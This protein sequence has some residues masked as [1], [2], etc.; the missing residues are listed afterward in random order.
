M[1]PVKEL[2]H[3]KE[4]WFCKLITS[5]RGDRVRERVKP[6]KVKFILLKEPEVYQYSGFI[7]IGYFQGSGGHVVF[8]V[9]STMEEI[10]ALFNKEEDCIK[11]YNDLVSRYLDKLDSLHVI[12][13]ARIEKEYIKKEKGK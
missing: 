8:S 2:V 7:R 6:S 1:I 3:D 9:Y 13:R 11:Y 10:P 5:R 4:Y 12:E